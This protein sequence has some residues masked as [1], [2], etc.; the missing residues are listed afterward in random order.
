MFK[1]I[2]LYFALGF[3][4]T[5]WHITS[6]SIHIGLDSLNNILNYE[7]LPELFTLR[8]YLLLRVCF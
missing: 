3:L 4:T 8:Q 7:S 1:Q 5:P 2:N 6:I